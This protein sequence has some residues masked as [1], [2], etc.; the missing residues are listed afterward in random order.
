MDQIMKNPGLQHIGEEILLNL[1]RKS[2]ME[3]RQI[4]ASWKNIV[5]S[6][7]FLIKWLDHGPSLGLDN[8][9]IAQKN[10]KFLLKQLD[11]V[12]ITEDEF[13]LL[14]EKIYDEKEHR[15]MKKNQF[16]EEIICSHI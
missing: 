4:N 12:S 7:M 1:D 15:L 11:N 14:L 9:D 6:R 16:G 10:W 2:L 8:V 5:N 13:Y 3:C